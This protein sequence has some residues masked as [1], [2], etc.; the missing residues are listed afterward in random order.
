MESILTHNGTW[1]IKNPATGNH[2]TFQVRT[3]SAD[4]KLAGKRIVSLLT[5]PDNT[6]DYIGFGFV[7]KGGVRVWRKHEGTVF[8]QYG[9]M[10]TNLP[11]V[12][13]KHGLQISASCCC[14][15][16]NRDLTTPESVASGIGP[17]CAEKE[18]GEN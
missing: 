11:R 16:C 1:T 5:G 4:S 3:A 10:L 18:M 7:E 8:S 17:T 9:A 6:E 15:R 2:R 13:E 12:A 14:R